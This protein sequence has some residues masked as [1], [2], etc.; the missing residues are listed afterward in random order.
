MHAAGQLRQVQMFKPCHELPPGGQFDEDEVRRFVDAD[1]KVLEGYR[2][3]L[4]R[5]GR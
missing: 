2:A 3:C 4:C 5:A 1:I